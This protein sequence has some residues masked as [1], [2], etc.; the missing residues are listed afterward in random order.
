MELFAASEFL[1]NVG[2]N[3]SFSICYRTGWL[4]ARR[5]RRHGRQLLGRPENEVSRNLRREGRG[6][7]GIVVASSGANNPD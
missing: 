3:P 5:Q 4:P 6:S 7:D 1:G 2:G